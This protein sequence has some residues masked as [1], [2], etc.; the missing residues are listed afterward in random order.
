[1]ANPINLFIVPDINLEIGDTLHRKPQFK[2]SSPDRIEYVI[3]NLEQ[4]S[5]ILKKDVPQDSSTDIHG[6]M[7]PIADV[8]LPSAIKKLA[9]IPDRATRF[10]FLHPPIG[11]AQ[12]ID[13]NTINIEE[14]VKS[15]NLPRG[16]SFSNN[17]NTWGVVGAALLGAYVYFDEHDYLLAVNAI[18]LIPTPYPLNFAGPFRPTDVVR[19]ELKRLERV[20][21]ITIGAFH[22]VS[23]VSMAFT[24]PGEKFR[25]EYPTNDFDKGRDGCFIFFKDN[26]EAVL[27][28]VDPTGYVDPSGM[29]SDVSDTIDYIT[30]NALRLKEFGL[31]SYSQA[32]FNLLEKHEEEL[33]RLK[34]QDSFDILSDD[35]FKKEFSHNE[36]AV[37]IASRLNCDKKT[38]E[39]LLRNHANK[40]DILLEPAFHRWTPLHYA[41]RFSSRNTEL[42]QLL[43]DACPDAVKVK[44]RHYR[45]PLH[46]A[47]ESGASEE[48]VRLL[49]DAN[50]DDE[51]LFTPSKRLLRLPLHIACDSGCDLEVIRLLLKKTKDISYLRSKT[52]MGSTPLHLA[53]TKK[54][55]YKIIELLVK[56]EA[57][58]IPK[59]KRKS[60]VSFEM[61]SKHSF[62]NLIHQQSCSGNLA[63]IDD[64]NTLENKIQVENESQDLGICQQINGMLP[65]HYACWNNSSKETISVLL[66]NDPSQKS[67]ES[68]VHLSETVRASQQA[69][70]K[71][72]LMS[73]LHLALL[74]PCNPDVVA[75]L[76]QKEKLQHRDSKYKSTIHFRD[77]F[78]RI[79]LHLACLE[80][81]NPKIISQLLDLDTNKETTHAL[82]KYSRTPLYY[83]CDQERI[84]DHSVQILLE[85]EEYFYDSNIHKT[86]MEFRR[87]YTDSATCLKEYNKYKKQFLLPSK[88]CTHWLDVRKKSPLFQA[89]TMGGNEDIISLLLKDDQFF[90]K[91]INSIIEDF[92]SI[93]ANAEKNELKDVLIEALTKRC[94]FCVLVLDIYSHIAAL[95]AFIIA[96]ENLLEASNGGTPFSS[97]A[98]ISVMWACIFVNAF[99][100]LIRFLT[101]R[102]HYLFDF[103]S[104]AEL[105]SLGSL[106]VSNFHF[107]NQSGSI[108][109]SIREDILIFT[110]VI[111]ILNVAFYLRTAFA[112]FAR[113]V[114]GLISIFA[115]LIP[116]FVVS[117]LIILAFTYGFRV[118]GDRDGCD[119]LGQCYYVVMG[120]FFSGADGVTDTLD[121][122]FGI[123]VIVILL[124]V[125]IAVVEQAWGKATDETLNLFWMYRLEFLVESRF[126]DYVEKKLIDEGPFSF[127]R[128]IEKWIDH[129][130]DLS[131][132]DDVRWSDDPYNIVMRKEQYLKPYDNFN[133]D[134]A[135]RIRAAHSTQASLFWAK[136]YV[137]YELPEHKGRMQYLCKLY[138]ARFQVVVVFARDLIINVCLFVLG[139]V[140]CGWFWPKYLR[141]KL[142]SVGIRVNDDE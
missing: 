50:T 28:T 82:D 120:A 8:T 35:S 95:V 40:K 30:H 11:F 122:L 14:E 15:L 127:V 129:V 121:I 6:W 16:H 125:L 131:I 10:A 90:L 109:P 23:F 104:Y 57:S 27:Y 142:L 20:I 79:P 136:N 98:S 37:H 26:G 71:I 84:D 21:P 61:H 13:W 108:N 74:K 80:S 105:I 94:Y 116:F 85:N 69:I 115:T 18:S 24:L 139:L 70:S 124:N 107:G 3:T 67:F 5:D 81:S 138:F 22:E 106:I 88:R 114:G 100:E 137:K 2:C 25:S 78:E 76:L 51:A 32:E 58:L 53:I 46:I 86:W 77:S 111:L 73:P 130:G 123:L 118:M 112:P 60:T 65:I 126:F 48:V 91:G 43:I 99:R 54:V 68:R 110:G 39:K 34:I 141:K 87:R 41:C 42:I 96:S 7:S 72:D 1:M 12:R 38:V 101:Q 49:L 140:S 133:K 63:D 19:E 62:R 119:G 36:N 56:R 33:F 64:G 92:A 66:D 59:K 29:V 89:I 135:E 128:R 17:N 9:G 102:S 117:F 4:F 47:L 132:K 83:A 113:F 44:D 97:D 93:I 134:V 55:D 103:W 31:I 52:K 75:L 45:Y